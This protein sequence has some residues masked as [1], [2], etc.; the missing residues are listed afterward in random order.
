MKRK[1]A[2]GPPGR[3]PADP[4]R[5]SESS[6]GSVAAY[7]KSEYVDE[8]YKCQRCRVTTTFTALDQKYTYEV[9]KAN[10]N[11]NRTLCDPCWRESLRIAK[12]LES[13]ATAWEGS[14]K[15]LKTDQAFLANWLG[16]LEL[17]DTYVPHRPDVAR[18]NMLRKCLAL[19]TKLFDEPAS[20]S[21]L[22]S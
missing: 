4:S 17:R 8:H 9:H 12:Q 16:L 11:Q 22:K 13:Q 20:A 2:P 15:T 14:K 18:K 10:V 19:A 6:Q 1:T 5:W 21:E 7:F 3:T